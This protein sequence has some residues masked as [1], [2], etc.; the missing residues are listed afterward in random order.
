MEKKVN[1]VRSNPAPLSKG[2]SE[3]KKVRDASDEHWRT[4]NGTKA[5]NQKLKKIARFFLSPRII[6]VLEEKLAQEQ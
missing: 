3:Y 5:E 6:P 1:P 2:R 4:S